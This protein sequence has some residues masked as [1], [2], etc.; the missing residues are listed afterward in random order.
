MFQSLYRRGPVGT[1]PIGSPFAAQRLPL[2][3]SPQGPVPALWPP[4]PGYGDMGLLGK[5]L[6]PE[7][8][9]SGGLLDWVGFGD[10]LTRNRGL[11]G[12]IARNVG[13]DRPSTGFRASNSES[14]TPE[15]CDYLYWQVDI[16]TCRAIE[17]RRGKKAAARCYHLATA[18]YAACLHGV[19]LQDLPPLD[20]WNM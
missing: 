1:N 5:G 11:A 16:P 4:S 7:P 19:P 14:A 18:R 9:P 8:P 3:Q 12:P 15:E 17:A 10:F 13:R 6:F 20:T 2:G